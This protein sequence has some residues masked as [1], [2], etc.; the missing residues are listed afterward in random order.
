MLP[1]DERIEEEKIIGYKAE[2]FYPVHL[3]EVFKSRY[4]VVAKLGFG[5][6]STVW[7]CRDLKYVF[8]IRIMPLMADIKF[9]KPIPNVL[10]STYYL[11]KVL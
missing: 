10:L 4:Q 7:L 6:S 1:A 11:E 5:G 9:Y 3:G 2:R 8:V